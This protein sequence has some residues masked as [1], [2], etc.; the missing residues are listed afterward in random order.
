MLTDVNSLHCSKGTSFLRIS[1]EDHRLNSLKLQKA[2]V[3]P[4]MK[5][6]FSLTPV[7]RK[8]TMVAVY[9]QM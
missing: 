8:A 6:K 3:G 4:L 1:Q 2:F 9:R 7:E 5:T